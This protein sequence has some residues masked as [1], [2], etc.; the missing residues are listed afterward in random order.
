M[1]PVFRLAALCAALLCSLVPAL[2]ASTGPA[3]AAP[4]SCQPVTVVLSAYPAELSAV[5]ARSSG[6]RETW[7]HNNVSFYRTDIGGAPV[8]AAMTG[9]GITNATNTADTTGKVLTC[10]AHGVRVQRILFSGTAGGMPPAGIGDVTVPSTWFLGRAGRPLPADPALLAAARTVHPAL[11]HATDTANPLSPCACDLPWTAP[12]DLHRQPRI[13][14]GGRGLSSDPYRGYSFPCVPGGGAITGCRPC[15]LADR[16]TDRAD[17]DRLAATD[18]RVL[19]TLLDDV[20]PGTG[21]LTSD[22]ETAAVAQM[23]ARSHIPFL[24]LRGVSDGPDDP[25]RLP[26]FPVS[27]LVYQQLA[28]TNAAAVAAAVITSTA[29]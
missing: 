28:A 4:A 1:R 10:A 22:M 20:D 23:A 25:N 2:V 26:G 3:A 29:R 7:T 9:V 18:A 12:I 21:Y 17:L 27:F 11:M 16:T 13:V 15:A 5:L 8:I 14:V 19:A 6:V 24:G